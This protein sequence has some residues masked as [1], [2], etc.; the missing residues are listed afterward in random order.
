[1]VLT[2]LGVVAA[3]AGIA[4]SAVSTCCGS[5]DPAHPGPTVIGF[6]VGI[7]LAAAGVGLWS[8]RMSRRCVLLCSAVAPAVLLVASAWSV[9]VQGLVPFVVLG[10]LGLW[11]YLR[12]RRATEW[13]GRRGP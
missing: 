4:L 8:G 10:W 12:R 3:L 11:W 5:P 13:L 1:V 7:A 6:V 2:L 9:D